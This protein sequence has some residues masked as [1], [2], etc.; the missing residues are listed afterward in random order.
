M[1]FNSVMNI[2]GEKSRDRRLQRKQLA[3]HIRK[4]QFGEKL[5]SKKA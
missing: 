4:E 5:K 3:K 1:E 2:Q